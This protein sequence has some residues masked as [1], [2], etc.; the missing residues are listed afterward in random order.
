LFFQIFHL[1]RES[2]NIRSCVAF[3]LGTVKIQSFSSLGTGTGS[4]EFLF[5]GS[6]Q[7]L[8]LHLAH[9]LGGVGVSK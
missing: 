4:F 5:R 8:D 9:D 2:L 1:C 3:I 6:L 7:Y